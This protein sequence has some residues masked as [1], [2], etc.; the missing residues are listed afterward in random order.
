MRAWDRRA[1]VTLVI[2]DPNA[3][4]V[5]GSCSAVAV[6][7]VEIAKVEK[8]QIASCQR[9]YLPHFGKIVARLN[10]SHGIWNSASFIPLRYAFC[11]LPKADWESVCPTGID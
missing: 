7:T 8:T 3:T 2:R 4:R 10:K 11:G 6:R 9:L 5:V 1:G